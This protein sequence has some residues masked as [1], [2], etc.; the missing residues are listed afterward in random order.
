MN[1]NIRISL[2]SFLLGIG[3]AS[4]WFLATKS[5][6]QAATV[7]KIDL[8][9][10]PILYYQSSMHPWV[11]SDKPGEC[12]VCGMALV[13]IYEG[14]WKKTNSHDVLVLGKDSLRVLNPG[15]VMVQRRTL[16]R[17]L[18]VAGTIDVDET[19]HRK[20]SANVP[21]RIE[22]LYPKSVGAEI[23]RDGPLMTIYSPL[24]LEIEREYTILYR[25]SQMNHSTKITAEHA[26]LLAAVSQKL[27]QYGLTV[28]QIQN[29]KNKPEDKIT[30]DILATLDGTVLRQFVYEGQ[31]VEEGEP[32]FEVADFFT[33]WFVF[34]VYENDLP[35]IK[36]GQPVIISV[37]ALPGR[38]LRAPIVLVDPNMETPTRSARVRV[39]IQNP[40]VRV[41][42]EKQRGLL[43]EMYATGEIKIEVQDVLAIP[44]T[45]VLNTGDRVVVFV[46]QGGGGYDRR[47]IKI[48]RM[49]D[50]EVE[51][52]EGLAEGDRVVIDGNL[53]L[54]GQANLSQL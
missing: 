11:K 47:H 20:I 4:G 8:R 15:T 44:R 27:L 46:D 18:K 6:G 50:R 54:D 12:T 34:D 13:P 28:N 16:T 48:G 32:L 37:P 42:G 33:M 31:Y 3:A 26:R 9:E 49:G 23:V 21:G 17:T 35:S 40:T 29:L 38:Q 45:A 52:S 2:L 14:D 1:A 10:R 22:K 19:K 7:A 5:M 43:R 25:Q 41:Q 39:E 36:I 51:V 53:L 30:S 24:L